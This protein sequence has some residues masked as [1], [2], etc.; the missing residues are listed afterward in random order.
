[1]PLPGETLTKLHNLAAKI[2]RLS[3]AEKLLMASQLVKQS[4]EIAE[5]IARKAADEL[6][7][8]RLLGKESR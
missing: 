6:A 2:D 1:M 5:T 4:P 7:L 3:P 8:M